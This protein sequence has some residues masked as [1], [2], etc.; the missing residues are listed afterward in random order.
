MILYSFL[1]AGLIIMVEQETQ[2]KIPIEIAAL[3]LREPSK[4]KCGDSCRYEILDA[5]KLAVCCIAD[6]VSGAAFDWK[7]SATACDVF[8][9]AFKTN[10]AP[11]IV[12][13]IEAAV[14][15]ANKGF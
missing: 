9:S 7:A 10:I 11:G 5:E 14:R 1:I 15:A 2:H 8:M 4:A 3:C 6:G 12:R 13:R